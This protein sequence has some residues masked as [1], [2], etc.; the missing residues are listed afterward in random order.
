MKRFATVSEVSAATGIP[1]RTVRRWCES[2]AVP[3]VQAAPGGARRIPLAD[4]AETQ[5][6]AAVAVLARDMS[7]W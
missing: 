3:S 1:A 5:E 7:G 2:G 6:W 4:L